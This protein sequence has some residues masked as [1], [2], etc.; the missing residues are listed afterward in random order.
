MKTWSEYKNAVK[1]TD[2][3]A[4]AIISEAEHFAE[5]VNTVSRQIQQISPVQS[6]SAWKLSCFV[7]GNSCPEDIRNIDRA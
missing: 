5:A 7:T 4:A 1:Q 6:V 3:E 2:P